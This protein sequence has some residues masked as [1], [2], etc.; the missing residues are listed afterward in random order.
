M[1]PKF[2]FIFR[3]L[4]LFKIFIII[5]LY[6]ITL[7]V[8]F[9][10][11]SIFQS[12]F[13]ASFLRRL[14]YTTFFVLFWISILF[15][16]FCTFFLRRFKY[17]EKIKYELYL[18]NNR[19]SK[20]IELKKST[21]IYSP[22]GRIFKNNRHFLDLCNFYTFDYFFFCN[23][24]YFHTIY[25]LALLN[26]YDPWQFYEKEPKEGGIF[27]AP[28]QWHLQKY[29]ASKKVPKY[30]P[31]EIEFPKSYLQVFKIIWPFNILNQ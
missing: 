20:N 30:I 3:I 13:C 24:R 19:I 29:R 6:I 21:K 31:K 14:N 5:F 9:W 27:L 4:V 11:W 25:V 17:C 2:N 15:I 7:L 10:I 1:L 28:K 12:I 22:K 8:P 18:L 26:V 16:P 23:L